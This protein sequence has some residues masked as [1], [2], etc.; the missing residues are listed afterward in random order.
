MASPT[1][2]DLERLAYQG[3]RLEVTGGRT[4]CEAQLPNRDRYAVGTRHTASLQ[5]A[6][7]TILATNASGFE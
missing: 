5:Y 7:G 6:R 1:Y 3:V 2:C 4:T